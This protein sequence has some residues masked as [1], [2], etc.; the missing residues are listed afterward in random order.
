[1]ISIKKIDQV[2]A[3]ILFVMSFVV[4]HKMSNL[5]QDY[6]FVGGERVSV[7]AI[8]T[9]TNDVRSKRSD[10]VSWRPANL[11]DN[12]YNNDK[13]FTDSESEVAIKLSSGNEIIVK[14]ESVFKINILN[15]VLNLDIEKGTFFANLTNESDFLLVLLDGKEFKL[16]S[17]DAKVKI[18]GKNIALLSGDLTLTHGKKEITLTKGQVANVAQD[19]VLFES[20]P[21]ELNID[22]KKIYIIKDQKLTI[23]WFHNNKLDVE[24]S[25][26][27][28]F[29]NSHKFKNTFNKLIIDKSVIREGTSFIKFFDKIS[30]KYSE[31]FSFNIFYEYSPDLI[32]SSQTI[33]EGQSTIL[34]ISERNPHKSYDLFLDDKKEVISSFFE[35]KNLKAGIYK[36]SVKGQDSE[37]PLSLKS[38]EVKL[39]VLKLPESGPKIIEPRANEEYY[40]Y[41]NERIDIK[42]DNDLKLSSGIKIQEETIYYLDDKQYFVPNTSGTFHMKSFYEVEGQQIWSDD[43]LFYVYV[44]NFLSNPE[45]GKKIVLKKPGQEISFDWEEKEGASYLFEISKDKKFKKILKTKKLKTPNFETKLFEVGEFYWRA[46]ILNSKGEIEYSKPKKVIFLKPEPPQP[47]KIKGF[48]KRRKTITF[49]NL[50]LNIIFDTAVA[51]DIDSSDD[52]IE[53]EKV[54]GV[55]SYKIQIMKGDNIIIDK[56]IDQNFYSIKKL[57]LGKY[58]Y[59]IASIDYWGQVGQFSNL[60]EIEIE[61]EKKISISLNQPKHREII[62]SEKFNF[63]WQMLDSKNLVSKDESGSLFN[64]LIAKDLSFSDPSSYEAKNVDNLDISLSDKESGTYYW[65]VV[66]GA[67]TSKRRSFVYEK[68]II[69]VAGLGLDNKVRL[70]WMTS[71]IEK[72]LDTASRSTVVDGVS[73]LGFSVSYRKE[74]LEFSHDL[75]FRKNSGQVF[76]S[77][78][79]NENLFYVNSQKKWKQI[80]IGSSLSFRNGMDHYVDANEKYSQKRHSSFGLGLS[81]FIPFDSYWIDVRTSILGD[82]S[83]NTGIF[84]KKNLWKYNWHLGLEYNF[85]KNDN[86]GEVSGLNLLLG[87]EL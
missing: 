61:K 12:V 24:I 30:K 29:L 32:L 33:Y 48:R 79:L 1:M 42:L 18:E 62:K 38:Q 64:V 26:T 16:K 13:I 11:L 55:K 72:K 14:E 19:I 83:F 4:W 25:D 70:Y 45:E 8:T 69:K 73:L 2:I 34:K 84:Y 40:I 5:K 6:P 85:F 37:R 47:P 20:F 57:K 49:L 78:D 41:N 76:D 44:D 71:Q 80:F 46:K 77:L 67:L 54:D 52:Q 23:S 17:R 50:F 53:W 82:T 87:F 63:S 56:I 58:K 27:K 22:N 74:F 68:P 81:M 10:Q 39:N 43:K 60:Q 21:R 75:N 51:Q 7:G 28:E 3:M 36:L 15:N 59:R 9:L 66:N 31:I 86:A 35:L 65:K